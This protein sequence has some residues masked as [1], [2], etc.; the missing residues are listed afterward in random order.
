M[1]AASGH[2]PQT[3]WYSGWKQSKAETISW[4][5]IKAESE[6]YV[7][8]ME[9][10]SIF[11]MS[12]ASARD[13]LEKQLA[14]GLITPEQY[15]LE[16]SGMDT[17][18]LYSLQAAAA[19]DLN[20]VQELLEAGDFENPI[21][22]QDLV[23]GITQMTLALLN[24]NKYEDVP[25]DTKLNFINWITLARAIMEQGTTQTDATAPDPAA[26]VPMGDP[27]MMGLPA[28]VP[29]P[30]SSGLQPAGVGALPNLA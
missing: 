16:L 29:V 4:E 12:P 10:V 1:I 21:P 20:R 13:E 24:L 22:E 30:E 11:S 8:T 17:E 5:D 27:G 18:S 25:D 6:S 23:S 9:A 15:R 26:A 2:N 28:A 14:M 19:D 7:M 3:T